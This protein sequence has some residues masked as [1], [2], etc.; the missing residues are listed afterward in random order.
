MAAA[1]IILLIV[2]NGAFVLI[3]MALVSSRRARLEARAEKGQTGAKVALRLLDRPTL[4][5]STVQIGI[6][7]TGVLLGAF[8]EQAVAARIAAQL[9]TIEAVK[10]F[11][12]TIG[13]IVTVATLTVVIIVAAELVPKRLA[14]IA[15][16]AFAIVGSRPMWLM[17]RVCAPLVWMLS[18]ATDLILRVVPLRARN[19]DQMVVEEVR[20]LVATGAEAGVVERAEQQIV[21]RVFKL[22]ELGVKAIM[23]PRTDV[24]FL[25]LS[26]S[27]Q[28]VRTMAATS[29]HSHFPVCRTGL[30]DLV[31]VVHVKDLVRHGLIRGDEAEADFKLEP[32]VKPPLFVPESTSAISMLE[33]FRERQTHIAFVLDEYGVLEGLVTLYD[34]LESLVGEVRRQGDVDDPSVVQRA[35]GSYLLDGMLSVADLKEL[36]GTTE[37][38]HEK[39][40]GYETLGGMVMT[41]LGR[42]PAAG[43]AFEWKDYRFEVMDMD[44]ARVDKVMMTKRGGAGTEAEAG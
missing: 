20:A 38:P 24:R 43:D 25:L 15:P 19:D 34:V 36:I 11:A 7:L 32:L 27:L 33:T 41:Y 31:G 10:P 28:N 30:D 4:Y 21:E 23:V 6:T 40:A 13:L 3:E 26:D 42:I 5:L 16:E 29:A 44:K 37:L 1:L 17:S 9:E 22:G 2:V 14:Q 35:D 12:H 39:M 18:A 8:G